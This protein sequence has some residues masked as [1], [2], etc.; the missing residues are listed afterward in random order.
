MLELRHIKK[1][2]PI[3][4]TDFVAIKNLSLVFP[5]KGFIA[6]LGPSG[7][8]K[9]TLLN[10][11]GGLDHYSGGDLLIDGKSTKRFE[12]KDWDAYRNNR[13]GFIFQS[14]NLIPH[15]TVLSNVSTGLRLSGKG[16]NERREKAMGVLKRV[17]LE[18]VAKKRPSQLSGGQMQRVA[19]ARAL[20]NDPDIILAD[21]PTGALDS[22]TSVQVLDLIKEIGKDRLVIM[23]T[24][25]EE[26]AEQYA[27]RII[28]MKDG[29]VVSDS[30]PISTENAPTPTGSMQNK[31]SSMSFLTALKSSFSNVRT[32]KGRTA[33]TAIACSIGIIGVA[34]VLATNNGFTNYIDNV[35]VAMASAV[36]ITISP[37][38]YDYLSYVTDLPKEF[39][40]EKVVF[41]D[42]DS[43]L[44]YVSHRNEFSDELIQYLDRLMTDPKLSGLAR[45]IMY[46]HDSLDF[47]FITDRGITSEGTKD[48]RYFKVNQ[49]GSAGGI[50]SGIQ[51]V[52]GL[53]AT[54]IHELYGNQKQLKGLYEVI[55]GRFPE[56]TSDPNEA[57][58]V[59]IVD[60]Y[61]QL[62]LT[63]LHNLGIVSDTNNSEKQI[64]F[65]DI[66]YDGADDTEYKEYKCYLNSDFYQLG[67][68]RE[69]LET[70]GTYEYY[71]SLTPHVK[72]VEKID[73]NGDP[74]TQTTIEIDGDYSTKTFQYYQQPDYYDFEKIYKN[75]DGHYHPINCKIVGVI[76]PT[77]ESFI[78][79]MPASIGYLT[80]LKDRMVADTESE[81][82]SK[83]LADLQAK[84]W[85]IERRDP[86][87][88]YYATRDGVYLL[89]NAIETLLNSTDNPEDVSAS[90]F[91]GIFMNVFR[92]LNA[93]TGQFTSSYNTMFGWSRSYGALYDAPLYTDLNAFG[94]ISGGEKALQAMAK[95]LNDFCKHGVNYLTYFLSYSPISSILI[96]PENMETKQQL[97]DYLDLYNYVGYNNQNAKKASAEQIVFSDIADTITGSIGTMINVISIVLIVFASISL[98]VSSVMTTIIT[99][100][101]VIERTKEIGILRA[102]GARKR[103]VGRLFEAESVIVG[104]FAGVIGIVVSV[105]LCIPINLILDHLF[106][107]NGL[108]SIA[109][110]NPW[111][112]L[113]LFGISVLLAFLSGFVPSRIA[114]KKDPVECLRSE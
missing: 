27:D 52:T 97:K 100:V 26:L 112:G 22:V 78:S 21:E 28:R 55:Y 37:T 32:K 85:M 67:T 33:L 36:P 19:I 3:D 45:S 9:T 82:G 2:Y 10:I 66:V 56:E 75:E 44:T 13:C 89:N 42:D 63:S 105:L 57:E 87:D 49:Y 102:C 62:T 43:S 58:M 79:L 40:E 17:G 60:R 77:E 71:T 81:E 86:S 103:D 16:L 4:K 11:I 18:E 76:R 53:P 30:L 110:L 72:N 92:Y 8:G 69:I 106:P 64:K 48:E 25:N 38:V 50:S 113:L 20:A 34:L 95:F 93:G 65:S 35:Q 74:Y 31:K 114:A 24:H 80:S 23:V 7:C 41:V 14:Y 70:T 51:S 101:S 6:I 54:R 109:S 29:E 5:D 73:E 1:V 59:L 91:S 61:N 84:N 83:A 46:N 108:G 12:D 98:V 68:P 107:G 104:G 99:Y 88:D 96:F 111:H 94:D 47:H 15:E 39:P 90:Q